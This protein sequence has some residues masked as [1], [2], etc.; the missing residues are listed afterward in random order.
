M[1][2]R[3][4][5]ASDS[6]ADHFESLAQQVHAGRLGMW[7]F[8]ASEALLFAALFALYATYRAMHPEAFAFGVE[9]N[10]RFLGSLNTVVLLTSSF[11]VAAS[12]HF[13]ARRSQ[14]ATLLV[15]VT[16]LLA[17]AFLVVKGIEYGQHYEEGIRLSG[18]G[19]FFVEHPRHGLPM[20]FLLYYA[21]TG[22]HAIHVVIGMAVLS[23][24]GWRLLR[25]RLRPP[26]D[27]PLHL[28]ALYWHLV[29]VIWIFLWPLFYLTAGG[30][31]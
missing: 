22:L 6:H 26:H 30:Q 15:G 16:V 9:H 2:E 19:H 29:D 5:D 31:R 28:G 3:G 25:R 27:H 4:H 23:W 11:T 7:I 17:G 1:A 8:L 20:F 24:L 18:T 10:S 14:L 12:T 13:V 21:M